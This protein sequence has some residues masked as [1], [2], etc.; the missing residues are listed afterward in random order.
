MLMKEFKGPGFTM[1]V[2]TDWYITSTPQIQAMF[3]SPPQ[4]GGF[5]AN[6]MITMN[7][8]EE[9]VTL[10]S[11][12]DETKQNQ[13]AQYP[14]YEVQEEGFQPGTNQKAFKRTYEWFNKDKSLR[15][16]Q[17]QVMILVNGM[18]YV[19]T[20]TRP[21]VDQRTEDIKR[22]DAQLQMMVESFVL[23]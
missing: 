22:I 14:E 23:D 18:V 17:K 1:Q 21:A 10:E 9:K 6:L 11:I 19:L 15:V 5:Q 8:V 7:P 12:A 16:Y 4:E 2:P 3:I 20:T 13:I